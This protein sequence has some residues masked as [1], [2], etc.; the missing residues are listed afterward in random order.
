MAL[1][2]IQRNCRIRVTGLTEL[3][4]RIDRDV[5]TVIIFRGM[6]GNTV[7][8]TVFGGANTAMHCIVALVKQKLHVIATNDIGRLYTVLAAACLWMFGKQAAAVTI[9]GDC[10]RSKYSEN[11]RQ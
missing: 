3:P 5:L 7:L 4:L 9:V 2:A 8:E 1:K 11:R 6:T 10:S